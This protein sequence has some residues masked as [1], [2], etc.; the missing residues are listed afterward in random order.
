[1]HTPPFLQGRL[2][3]GQ[4]LTLEPLRLALHT[5]GNPQNA[6]PAVLVSGTNGKGSTTTFLSQMA[7]AAGLRV[8]TFCSPS[9]EDLRE[10]IQVDGVMLAPER[11][12]ALCEQVLAAQGPEG[13]TLFELATAAAFLTFALA[14]VQLAVIEVGMGGRED[15]TNLC[16][17]IVSIITTVALDHMAELGNTL[18]AIALQKVG[19]A[20]P[21]RPLI[22][23]AT[24]A[25]LTTLEAEC[26]ARDIPL[27][28]LGRDFDTEVSWDS[29]GMRV[30]FG[31]R[32]LNEGGSLSDL[33]LGLLGSHQAHNA[34]VALQAAL[35]L[36]KLGFSLPESALRAGLLNAY[37]PG[38]LEPIPLPTGQRVWLDGAHNPQGV[39]TLVEALESLVQS[40]RVV[41]PVI[42]VLAI[43]EDKD[44]TGMLEGLL[45]HVDGVVCTRSSSPRCLT[46]RRLG[47]RVQAWR[48]RH[49]SGLT[50]HVRSKLADALPLALTLADVS[51][52]PGTVLVCGS[53][54]LMAPARA[55]LQAPP[56]A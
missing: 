42:V 15:A 36:R 19:I 55:I 5:L 54:S 22:T 1:M 21:G 20:R 27:L 48:R 11:F 37:L 3:T 30:Q 46:P 14:P 52:L 38:R 23:G 50:C 6:F 41:R 34:A 32:T 8:G 10:L 56:G 40:G 13:L 26:D 39:Q 49:R 9:L 45:P 47:R 17:P 18:S 53:L 44:I 7:L 29:L 12:E 4:R 2:V 16:H 31:S 51:D 24:G 28:V 33:R 43:F 25:A 35:E